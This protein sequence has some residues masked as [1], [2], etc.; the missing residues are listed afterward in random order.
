MISDFEVPWYDKRKS[1]AEYAF[2]RAWAQSRNY[3]ADDA[4]M[5]EKVTFANGRIVRV[6]ERT[7]RLMGW[8]LIVEDLNND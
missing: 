6:A 2:A 1:L 7:K 3:V 4:V 8:Y 5:P